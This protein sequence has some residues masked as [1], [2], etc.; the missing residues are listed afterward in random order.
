MDE[1]LKL[2]EIACRAAVR[3]G[4][5]FADASVEQGRGVSISIE[6]NAIQSSDARQWARISV[7][8]FVNG[9]TGWFSGSGTSEEAAADAGRRAAEAAKAAE[10]DPDFVDLVSPAPLPEVPGLYDPALAE[11]APGAVAEWAVSNVDSARAVCGDAIVSGRSG[12]SWNRWA[13]ANNLGVAVT[14]QTTAASVNAHVVI[15]RGEDVGSFFEWDS[16]RGL[17]DLEVEGIGA[18]AASEALRY[19]GS[20]PVKTGVMPVVFG[21]LSSDGL[22]MGLCAAASAEEIQRRRSFLIGKK[23]EQV[24]SEALTL[25]DDPLIPGG[26]SSSRCDG[27][28]FPHRRLTLVERG[29]LKTYLHSH[30][31]ARKSGEENT[32]HSTRGGIAP[33]NVIPALGD[34]TAA[35]IITEVDDGIYVAL[36][37]PVPDTASG[38]LSTLVDAGFRIERGRLTHPLKNTM[39]AGHGLEVLCNIDVVSS[40]YRAEPGRVLPTVRVRAMN[41]AS[42]D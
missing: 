5:D 17:A 26:L 31:T 36:A 33:T 14:Q 15:R 13:F 6:K 32:G 19:L 29:V 3:A 16:A 30:Y 35:D 24:A 12:V 42:A 11:I 4:A 21:P 27:D 25:V 1:L 28:G 22:I 40:D 23:G 34:K 41:V 37:N 8:A 38:Q 2:A 39:I 10:P 7:R 18:R 9:G 20:R